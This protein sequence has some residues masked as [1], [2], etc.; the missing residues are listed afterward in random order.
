MSDGD[1]C[2]NN[3]KYGGFGAVMAHMLHHRDRATPAAPRPHVPWQPWQQRAHLGQ[4]SPPR[5]YRLAHLPHQTPPQAPEEVSRAFARSAGCSACCS[6]HTRSSCCRQQGCG[7]RTCGEE[8]PPHPSYCA[9]CVH[10]SSIILE[11]VGTEMSCQGRSCK[12]REIFGK[13]LNEDVVVHLR[14][15]QLMVEGKRRQGSQQFG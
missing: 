1:I 6:A 3:E 9:C 5:H 10:P 14:K 15:M 4:R 12:E 7:T 2:S 8:V 11:I 13:V